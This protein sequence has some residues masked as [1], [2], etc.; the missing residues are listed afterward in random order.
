MTTDRRR[1]NQSVLTFNVVYRITSGKEE[2]IETHKAFIHTKTCR[3]NIL[4]C[5]HGDAL[6]FFTCSYTALSYYFYSSD[7]YDS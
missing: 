3:D 1:L 7:L 5:L 6:Y 2:M 4:H